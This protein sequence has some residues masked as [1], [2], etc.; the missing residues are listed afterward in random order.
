MNDRERHT[1]EIGI[2]K[3]VQIAK[4]YEPREE[5][6][7]RI[8]RGYE[9]R[10]TQ[11]YK[12]GMQTWLN[13]R[14]ELDRQLLALSSFGIGFLITIKKMFGQLTICG[15]LYFNMAW[16]FYLL[17]ICLILFIFHKNPEVIEDIVIR[18]RRPKSL[19]Y[20]DCGIR[21]AFIVAVILTIFMAMTESVMGVK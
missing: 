6:S 9:D 10:K 15:K 11:F 2:Q 19:K 21:V 14:M 20:Y 13:Y 5:Y 7:K 16:I 18:Q 12:V 17:T 3:K 8:L 4:E 1:E